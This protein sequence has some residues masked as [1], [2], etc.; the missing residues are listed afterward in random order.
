[1]RGVVLSGGHGSRLNPFTKFSNKHLAPIYTPDGAIPIIYYPI[2]TLVDS[3]ITDILIISSQEHSGK[4]I[5]VLGDGESFGCDLTYKIQDMFNPKKPVGIASALKLS[6]G[7]VG[8]QS[9]AVILGDNYYQN[10]FLKEFI[11]FDLE[12][13]KEKNA[14]NAKIFLKQVHDP[15]RFGVATLGEDGNVVKIVEKP[16]EPESNWSVTGLYLYTPHVFSLVPQLKV[17]ARGELEI[18]DINNWYVQNGTMSG[19]ALSGHWTDMGTPESVYSLQVHLRQQKIQNG[20][21]QQV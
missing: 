13:K 18:T 11:D 12:T 20:G 14:P 9:F 4:I 7:F 3:G 15:E 2:K 10:N 1:M 16:K 21:H 8:D 19:A 17:S 6:Q 5:E